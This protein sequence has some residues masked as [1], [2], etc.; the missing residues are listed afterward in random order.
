MRYFLRLAYNGS[1]FHGWQ[2]QPDACSVQQR[3]EEV[4]SLILRKETSITGAGRTDTEVN[5]AEMYAHF[6]VDFPIEDERRFLH[7]V[8]SLL[9]PY[10]VIFNL[11]PVKDTAHARFDA[12]SRTYH[13]Y[14]CHLRSPFSRNFEWFCA[15][16]LDYDKMNEAAS[17]LLGSQDFTSFSRLHTDVK[18]NVCTITEASWKPYN[19]IYASAD[20]T[21]R[22]YFT[23]TANRFLRNMVRAI[24]G[25]LVEVGRNK[26]TINDFKEVILAK[27]RGVAGDSMPGHALF[28]QK[29]TYPENIFLP[30]S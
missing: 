13:Y 14:V 18:T 6:D 23:V 25:T 22:Y 17:I 11:I 29:I 2:R 8:N 15:S 12:L 9:A 20:S 30:K 26:M 24:V 1:P 7:S 3:I 10:I 27:N 16:K 19:Q 28:L 5:A 21:Q 4:I